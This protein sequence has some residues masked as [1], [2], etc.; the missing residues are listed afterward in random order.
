[1]MCC[2]TYYKVFVNQSIYPIKSVYKSAK[3]S[4]MSTSVEIA[5]IIYIQHTHTQVN[6]SAEYFFLS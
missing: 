1:M 6:L 5:D 2:V 4:G 3:P